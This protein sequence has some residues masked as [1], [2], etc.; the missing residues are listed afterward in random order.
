M[1]QHQL[2]IGE[3]APLIVNI[4]DQ[5]CYWTNGHLK[6]TIH[7]V[8][9]PRELLDKGKD[10]YSIV[11][12]A[13]PSDETLLEPVPSKII[14]QVKGR[15]ASHYMEKNGVAL[16]AVQHSTNRLNSTYSKRY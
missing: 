11:L 7:R 1:F 3:A 5:L 10:R 6:S 15:G 14:S 13:H 9:F 2:N 4:A 12:F 8:R 16:T